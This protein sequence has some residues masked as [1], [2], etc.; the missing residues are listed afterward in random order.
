M[1]GT[2]LFIYTWEPHAELVDLALV[3]LVLLG[4]A[5][6]S[7]VKRTL[8]LLRNFTV[9]RANMFVLPADQLLASIFVFLMVEKDEL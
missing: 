7:A 5:D 1:S 3:H 8:L 2:D 4:L 9:S 6:D